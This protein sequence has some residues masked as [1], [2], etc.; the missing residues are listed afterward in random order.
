[1]GREPGAQ[2]ALDLPIARGVDVEPEIAEQRQHCPAG[3]RL[4]RVAKRKAE[5]RAEREE[6]PCGPLEHGGVVHVAGSAEPVTHFG[7]LPRGEERHQSFSSAS[8]L[9][10]RIRSFSSDVTLV[11]PCSHATGDGCH[12]TNGQSLPSTTRSAPTSSSRKRSAFSLPT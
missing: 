3:I 10:Q 12:G 5:G 1:R 11:S 2:R 7:G 6:T 9:R 4:H 8:R